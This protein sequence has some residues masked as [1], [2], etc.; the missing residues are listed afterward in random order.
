MNLKP[1]KNHPYPITIVMIPFDQYS[2]FPKAVRDLMHSTHQPFELVIIEGNAPHQVRL[3]LEAIKHKHKNIKIIY[4]NHR[5][6]MAE[7]F[8]LAMPHIRT[9]YAFFMHNDVRVKGGWLDTLMTFALSHPAVICP[10]IEVLHKDKYL[11]PYIGYPATFSPAVYEYDP[12][13]INM[14]AFLMDKKTRQLIEAFDEKIGTALVGIELTEFMKQNS[15]EIK[16][17]PIL[18]HY[19]PP[20]LSKGQDLALFTNQWKETHTQET[21]SHL[22]KK[23]NVAIPIKMYTHWLGRKKALSEKKPFFLMPTIDR[24]GPYIIGAPKINLKR[25]I[26]VLKQA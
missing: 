2:I 26:D 5:P 9:E 3:D 10:K 11:D 13:S 7:A 20:T 17:A 14:H 16:Q 12:S 8:N 22:Q 4:S 24:S 6:R 21:L 23:W 25:F 1:K 15:I 19:E 18:L